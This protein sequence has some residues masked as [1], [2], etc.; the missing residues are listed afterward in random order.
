MQKEKETTPIEQVLVEAATKS[1]LKLFGEGSLIA[2]DYANRMKVPADLIERIYGLIDYEK[3]VAI[4]GEKINEQVAVKITHLMTEELT[5]DVKKAL[6]H[7]PTR[8]R[9]RGVVAAELE[10]IRSEQ[11]DTLPGVTAA[12]AARRS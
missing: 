12:Q 8:E 3:V 5:N 7:Q 11:R 2:P 10:K 1:I 6:C 9:L 4:L